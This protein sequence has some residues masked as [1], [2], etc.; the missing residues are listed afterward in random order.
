MTVID[1]FTET[2]TDVG[3]SDGGPVPPP[4]PL[5]GTDCVKLHPDVALVRLLKLALSVNVMVPVGVPEADSE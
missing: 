1:S 4:A 2:A 3:G 5:S